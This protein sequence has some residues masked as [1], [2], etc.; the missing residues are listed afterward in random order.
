VERGEAAGLGARGVEGEDGAG[1]PD[2]R[3]AQ[4]DVRADQ[5]DRHLGATPAERRQ[6][7]EEQVVQ[8]APGQEPQMGRHRG[9]G[10]ADLAERGAL[11]DDLEGVAG[12]IGS[13]GERAQVRVGRPPT[14]L[15]PGGRRGHG[16]RSGPDQV[17]GRQAVGAV[18]DQVAADQRVDRG[19]LDDRR[20]R[21]RHRRRRQATQHRALVRGQLGERAGQRV[22][23]EDPALSAGRRRLPDV[24][25]V[26]A[27]DR[28]D[29]VLRGRA[30][31][32]GLGQPRA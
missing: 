15:A 18:L 5:I 32:E 26:A 2:V 12:I 14:G 10:A 13:R 29:L 4:V 17:V 25:R 3:A 1:L 8:A 22:V 28:D 19:V 9:Q 21:Q 31:L 11:T 23:V 20:P 6:R 24:E 7:L 16:P 27:G 30:E